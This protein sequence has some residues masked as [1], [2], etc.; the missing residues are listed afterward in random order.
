METIAE[1]IDANTIRF[2]KITEIKETNNYDVDFLLKQLEDIQ[3]QKI[4]FVNARNKEQADIMQIL[5]H[6]YI[7]NTNENE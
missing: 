2:T 1:K 4:N 5:S 7:L 6:C 3:E